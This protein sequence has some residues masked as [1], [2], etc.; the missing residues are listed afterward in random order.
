M[1]VGNFS[2]ALLLTAIG[3]GIDLVSK[4][5]IFERLGMPGDSPIWWIWPGY[6]GFETSIN[7]GALFGIGQ[8]GV[9]VFAVFSVLA[10]IGWFWWLIF[11]QASQDRWLCLT[12]GL[13]GGGILGNLYDRLGLWGIRGVRDWIHLSYHELTWPNFNVADTLLVSGAMLI[14]WHAFRSE[15]PTT[16]E[17][18]SDQ[19][20]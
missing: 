3:C 17:P 5:W 20:T 18:T 19:D 12:L 14:V 8:G 9:V 10:I 4:N 16:A 1:H 2:A 15:P 7:T 11:G 6:V 13:I